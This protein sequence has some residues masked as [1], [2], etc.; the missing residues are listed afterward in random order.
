MPPSSASPTSAASS[1]RHGRSRS[2]TR[3]WTRPRAR[4]LPAAAAVAPRPAPAARA[5]RAA[6]PRRRPGGGAGRRPRAARAVSPEGLERGAHP[7]RNPGRAARDLD[8]RLAPSGPADRQ[9]DRGHRPGD[10]RPGCASRSTTPASTASRR[11]SPTRCSARCCPA[12]HPRWRSSSSATS[13]S[14]CAR[15][16]GRRRLRLPDARR[17]RPPSSSAT[18][19]ATASMP[20]PT[21]RWRSTCSARWRASTSCRASSWR[22]PT[23]SSL[24]HRPGPVHHHGRARARHGGGEVACASGGHPPPRLVLPDGRV[25]EIAAGG[26][27]LG[28]VA[29]QRYETVTAPFPAGC[30]RRR[31]HGRV[32]E[33]RRAASSSGSSGSTRCSRS[34][35]SPPREIAEAALAA[36][37]AWTD[38]GELKDDF[39]VVASP[40][41]GDGLAPGTRGARLRR[42]HRRARDRD[43]GVAVAR[44]VFSARPRSCGPI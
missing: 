35:A 27:A 7:D 23:T 21:W 18:S 29:P 36:C 4:A 33:A 19:P 6:A 16:G 20:P 40:N 28:I 37:R 26:L 17:R 41:P 31:L 44:S 5:E 30:D 3:G 32:V 1:W 12:P 13:T 9:R 14:R 22:P 8:H 15:G 34:T 25:E 24:R 11:P 38:G 42:R 39:A 43:R 10:C 2:T